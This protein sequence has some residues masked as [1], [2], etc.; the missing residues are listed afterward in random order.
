MADR[1]VVVLDAGTSA[2]RCFVF[3]GRA[4]AVARRSSEWPYVQVLGASPYAREFDT[5]ALWAAV[6]RLLSDSIRQAG[7]S[8]GEVAAVTATSQRQGLVFLDRDG[9]E[10]Y[11]GPNLDLR[12]V[13]EGAAID[14]EMRDAVY[15]T[16]GH[17]PS[18]MF[19]PAKLRWFQVHRPEDY[20]RIA[21]VLTLADWLVWKLTG[22]LAS[23]PSLAA[24]AGLLDIR[25]RQLCTDLLADMGFAYSPHI[26]LIEAGSIAGNVAASTSRDTGLDEGTPVAVS[27]ADTQCG[28]LG[29]GV[30]RERQA[31]VVA[32]WSAPVQAVTY[33]PL[34]SPQM[35]TWVGCFPIPG[36]WVLESNA[37]DAGNS[38]R[39][40]A[41]MLWGN[42][43]QAFSE[44]DAAAG[45]MPA[46]A[47]GALAFLGPSRMDVARVGMR[48]G[49]FLFPVPLTFSDMGR[50][51]MVRAAIEGICYA[52]KANLRQVDDLVDGPGDDI[53]V[54]GG[55]I[56]T[57]TFVRV[58]VDVLGR[59]IRVSPTPHV[60][61]LGAYLCAATAV[62]DFSSLE[63]AAGSVTGELQ[64]VEPEPLAAAD[65]VEHYQRWL[66][67]GE[68]FH[69]L[70]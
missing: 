3:D 55:M 16:T 17:L 11:A 23:E 30:S 49:G 62:G 38:Y 37:G 48:Q 58:L 50:G 39:W 19:T 35:R 63:E 33:R 15:Q 69:G 64:A 59:P 20:D 61:A 2:V 14:E 56:R 54:G 36:R 24:E 34:F 45:Q 10:L 29:M 6:R 18:F 41:D 13:F 60:S 25:R 7:A 28:L 52:L 51:H 21:T 57:G 65:Y 67:N 53:A 5:E 27:G 22:V 42:N 66:E 12:A 47:E 44:M 40:L 68:A 32:G 31:G 26:P 43:E 46:G 70:D 4:Q 8:P 9:H 1:Y